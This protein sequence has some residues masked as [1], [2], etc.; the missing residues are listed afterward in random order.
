MY[1]KSSIIDYAKEIGIDYIG[2]SDTN[3][4]KEF[5]GNLRKCREKN[6]LSGFEEEDE[7]K[8]V[9][10]DSVLPGA[11]TFISVAI[12][13]KYI[14]ISY[15]KPYVSKYTLG[16]DYHK[17]LANKLE[18][19]KSFIQ[20]SYKEKC[21]VFCDTGVFS[22][23]EIARKCGIGF[24]GKNTNIIT[25]NYGSYVF[26]GEIL[27]TLKIEPSKE[28]ENRCDK[29][30]LCIRSCPSKAIDKEGL[31]SKKCLSYV[32]QKK[33]E[34]TLG[35]AELLGTRVFGCDICQDVCPY[36]KNTLNSA[37]SE[38]VPVDY[39]LNIDIEEIL[40]MSNKEFKRKYSSHALAW[41]GKFIIQRNCIIA[42]GNSR[43]K[44]YISI[45]EN[46]RDDIRLKLYIE[47]AIKKLSE[48]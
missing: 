45:L 2:F 11:N 1:I 44:E 46:K 39:L 31:D 40:S 28:I 12:P 26:L 13:Y 34:L 36:N 5:I 43:N 47:T 48:L 7:F 21:M 32:S 29:C 18:L 30:D 4:T 41:R 14:N 22:D 33:E 9:D 23:K 24:I 15:N 8:R 10:V 16:N 42:C 3:F 20:E 25:K 6:K 27:T 37:I 19:L 38:F 35:E 17:T